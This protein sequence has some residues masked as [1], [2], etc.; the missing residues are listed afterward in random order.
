V[1]LVHFQRAVVQGS[2]GPSLG[3]ELQATTE[4]SCT[5]TNA[6]SSSGP[7]QKW[8]TSEAEY[9]AA[10]NGSAR[11][12]PVFVLFMAIVYFASS[13]NRTL[14]ANRSAMHLLSWLR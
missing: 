5:S 7:S 12:A 6:A 4:S 3:A 2:E 13:T 1:L 10:L 8:F 14:M 9:Y 11:A